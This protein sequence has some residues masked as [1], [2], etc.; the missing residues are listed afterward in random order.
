MGRFMSPDWSA[1]A[2]PVPYAKLDN[3]QSLNLYAYVNN[4]PLRM[5]DKDG[6]SADACANS[7]AQSCSVSVDAKNKIATVTETNQSVKNN[8]DKAGNVV[9][10]TVTTT[11]TTTTVTTG[12]NAHVEGATQTTSSTTVSLNSD[13]T[14]TTTNGPTQTTQLNTN[15]LIQQNP[16]RVSELTN[17]FSPSI[18]ERAM[19][20]KV[21]IGGGLLGGGVAVGCILAEPCG[22]GVAITGVVVGVLAGIYDYVTH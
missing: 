1:K 3:P 4:N 9:S 6:H 18:G 11:T 10:T 16:G 20:H 21:G 17:D 15:Q 22:A 8:T 14:K 12:V 2:E 7:S 13:G 5:A 19:D